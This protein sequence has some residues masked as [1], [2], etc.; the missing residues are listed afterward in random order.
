MTYS[1]GRAI[2]FAD[3]YSAKIYDKTGNTEVTGEVGTGMILK[4]FNSN[5][6]S[7]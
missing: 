6:S 1:S 7:S 5:T 4:I 2:T 3:G